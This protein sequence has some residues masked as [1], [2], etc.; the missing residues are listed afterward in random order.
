M[1]IREMVIHYLCC[2]IPLIKKTKKT[3][4]KETSLEI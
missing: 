3:K 1:Q 4:H 2:H